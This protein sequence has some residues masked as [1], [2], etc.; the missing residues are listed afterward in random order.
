MN[1]GLAIKNLRR[2]RGIKQGEMA[3]SIGM[4]DAYLSL[5]EGG[6][7]TPTIDMLRRIADCFDIPLSIL[8]WFT[9]ERD[10]ISEEK[11]EAYDTLKPTIDTMIT[12]LIK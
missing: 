4:N 9:I 2:S 5:I 6:K 11:R 8:F 10:E 12:S 3:K 7:R 1:I